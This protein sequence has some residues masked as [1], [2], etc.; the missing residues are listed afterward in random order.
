MIKMKDF[1]LFLPLRNKDLVPLYKI[2]KDQKQTDDM[3]IS[4]SDSF[5]QNES[6]LSYE[7]NKEKRNNNDPD[8]PYKQLLNDL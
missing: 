6:I 2:H 8:H 3:D 4:M 7:D 1:N 5:H